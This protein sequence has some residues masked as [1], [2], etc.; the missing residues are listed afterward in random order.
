MGA[1]DA[2]VNNRTAKVAELAYQLIVAVCPDGDDFTQW[3]DYKRFVPHLIEIA[4]RFTTSEP[5]RS[6]ELFDGAAKNLFEHGEYREALDIAEEAVAAA[7]TANLEG[8]HRFAPLN[9]VGLA[10]QWLGR[11]V[12][13]EQTLLRA[14]AMKE[15]ALAPDHP[16]IAATLGNLPLRAPM[17]RRAG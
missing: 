6:V 13:A 3:G 9:R 11:F 10:Q 2:D 16:E 1:T 14:L 8:W 7:E 17:L 15:I 5:E 4:K 12:Q